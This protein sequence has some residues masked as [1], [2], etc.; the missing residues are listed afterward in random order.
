MSRTG[1]IDHIGIGVPDLVAAKRY[2]DDVMPVLGLRQWFKTTHGG[3][4]NYGP[5]GARGA[6]LF[7]YQAREPGTYRATI[8]AFITSHSSSRAARSS[9]KPTRGRARTTQ[10]SSMNHGISPST[11]STT[12][13]IGSTR[14]D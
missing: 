5:D 6:Q 8:R 14:T 2:Y 1:F 9:A 11:V 3:P 13:R 4:F 12:R 7:F 10:R